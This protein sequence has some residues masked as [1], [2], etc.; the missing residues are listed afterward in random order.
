MKRTLLFFITLFFLTTS[1]GQGNDYK[2]LYREYIK[3]EEFSKKFTDWEWYLDWCDSWE[4]IYLDSDEIPELVLYGKDDATG[5]Y[6]LSVQSGRVVAQA[7]GDGF[8]SYIPQ[9]GLLSSY[10]GGMGYYCEYV[11]Y[12]NQ[13][14]LPVLVFTIVID[15]QSVYGTM[16]EEGNYDE[17][18]EQ[19][20][21]EQYSQY[22][23]GVPD[24][25]DNLTEITKEEYERAMNTAYH[26]KGKPINIR[27]SDNM[28]DVDSLIKELE[29]WK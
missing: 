29:L 19:K 5:N 18:F 9:S 3:S 25:T 6:I 8:P 27:L 20:L 23:R 13:T 16:E 2:K 1:Y 21:I 17:A 7:L 4:Y 24:D 15:F 12:L 26:S 22:Y 11:L 10:Y 28:K 14:F